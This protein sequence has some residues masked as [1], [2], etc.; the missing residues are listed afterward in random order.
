MPIKN[1]RLQKF[2][3]IKET[4]L[5]KKLSIRQ[6]AEKFDSYPQIIRY[7]FVKYKIPLR[8]EKERF[9]VSKNFL[10]F[11]YLTKKLSIRKI[12][13]ILKTTYATAR[14]KLIKY[15]IP[16][17][18]VSEAN[19]KYSKIPFNNNLTE[20]AYML[21][22]RTGDIS[23][24]KKFSTNSSKNRYYTSSTVKNVSKNV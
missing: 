11:L 6:I 24:A 23:A 15:E 22:L 12:A 7:W 19:M 18:T 3:T 1:G 14:N 9:K 21:G 17:R 10:E 8:S 13:K 5:A 4:L 20:K 16:L 2:R